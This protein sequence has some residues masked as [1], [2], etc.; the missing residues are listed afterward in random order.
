MLVF[1]EFLRISSH[2]NKKHKK[3]AYKNPEKS[4]FSTGFNK[5]TKL[6]L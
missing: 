1:G 6:I 2:F 4:V 5:K 3:I